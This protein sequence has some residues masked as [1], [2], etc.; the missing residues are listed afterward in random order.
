MAGNQRPNGVT[1]VGWRTVVRDPRYAVFA[2][3]VIGII[4]AAVVWFDKLR[5]VWAQLATFRPAAIAAALGCQVVKYLAIAM[6][7]HLLLRILNHRIPVPYLFGSGIAMVFFNQTM[8]SMGTSGNAFMYAALQRRGVSGG[9][10]VIV[11]I[12]NMLTYYI[13][14]FVLTTSAMVYLA[15]AHAL[16]GGD[17]AVTAVFFSLMIAFF[18]WIRFRTMT[19]ERLRRTVNDINRLISRL[20]RGSLAQAIPDHFADELFEGR[21]LIV[22]A[23]KHFVLPVITNLV[24]FLA[25]SA[26]LLVVL[27]ALGSEAVLYRHVVGAYVVGVIL[28]A[29]AIVPGALGLYEFGM[30]GMLVF[31]GIMPARAVAGTLL[32]RGFSFW[33]P[34]PVGF[35]VYSCMVHAR[36]RA[37]CP[38]PSP[39]TMSSDGAS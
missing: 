16:R 34:I 10:A 20:S 2:L 25:D 31:F 8:P 5:P 37:V 39:S 23:K 13:A 35:I 4:V 14:F 29:F 24:M 17:V 9:S 22:N 15:L 12:L 36:R 19:I 32:F 11:T 28:Y 6:T 27:K 1:R 3:V 26:T 33:L 21:A 18:L 30:T 38:E 7:F